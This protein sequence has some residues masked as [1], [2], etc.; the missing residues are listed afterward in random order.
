MTTEAVQVEGEVT[1]KYSDMYEVVVEAAQESVLDMDVDK[2]MYME[3]E[4][5]EYAKN[6]SVIV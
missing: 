2:D 3:V 1:V 6:I 4:A 5:A